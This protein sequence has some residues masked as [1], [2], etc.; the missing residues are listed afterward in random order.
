MRPHCSQS[1]RKNATPSSGTS[2][3]ASYEEK[4]PGFSFRLVARLV[5]CLVIKTRKEEGRGGEQQKEKKTGRC[6]RTGKGNDWV[7]F[8]RF[9]S[10]PTLQ[11]LQTRISTIQLAS[12]CD[13][14]RTSTR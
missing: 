4:P 14:G 12:N 11:H 6:K 7:A 13:S 1:S 5:V 8:S 3:L 2:P 9:G 10:F